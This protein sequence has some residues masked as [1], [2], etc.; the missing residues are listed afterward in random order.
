MRLCLTFEEMQNLSQVKTRKKKTQLPVEMHD[1][2]P[3]HVIGR[4]SIC[5]DCEVD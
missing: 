2:L 3:Y 4:L 5:F 1:R